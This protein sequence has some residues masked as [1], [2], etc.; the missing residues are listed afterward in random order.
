MKSG[1]VYLHG[2]PPFPHVYSI[3]PFFLKVESF[4]RLHNIPYECRWVHKP[5]KKG[6]I[7]YVIFDGEEIDDSNVIIPQLKARFSVDCDKDIPASERAVGH[8]MM[9]MIE[10]HTIQIGFYYR[11]GLHMDRF[12][13]VLD[14]PRAFDTRTSLEKRFI[15]GFGMR[16]LQPWIT[17]RKMSMRG[18]KAH[19]DQELWG[20]SNDD[21][22]AISG[23]L[24]NRPYFHGEQ[25]TTTDCMLFG[26][27]VQFLDIPM[28]Y[29]QKRFLKESCP[30]VVALVEGSELPTGPTGLRSAQAYDLT[31]DTHL[32]P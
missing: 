14:P 24:G 2:F 13:E 20:F 30:N 4:L 7:P 19:S 15:V 16:R 25:A 3:S 12:F 6:Q 5:G 28:D 18:L 21:L 17:N 26:H 11:Y 23:Y 29:P 27:L 10:E 9:R 1:V 22:A 31:W 8:A 32:C